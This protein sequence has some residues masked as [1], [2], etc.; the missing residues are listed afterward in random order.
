[1]SIDTE[2]G[3]GLAVPWYWNIAPNIDATL[4]PFLYTRRGSCP[5]RCAT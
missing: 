3:F 1:M 2:A 5:P 4:T